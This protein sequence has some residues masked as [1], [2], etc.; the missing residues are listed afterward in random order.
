MNALT[1]I[2]SSLVGLHVT[3][4]FIMSD[5]SC[6]GRCYAH[7]DNSRG[8][9]C[10]Y[11]CHKYGDCCLD[12][13]YA[14]RHKGTSPQ[15]HTG[16]PAATTSSP[17]Q[18]TL[19]PHTPVSRNNIADVLWQVDP[20][21]FDMA[22]ITINLGNHAISGK[23]TDV[24]QD[25]LFTHVNTAPLSKPIYKALMELWD[26]YIPTRGA[27][28][29]VS[30]NDKA[31]IDNF[32]DLAMASPVMET[33]YNYLVDQHTFSGSKTVFRDKIFSLWFEPYSRSGGSSKDSS[34]FEHVF[35][36]EYKSSIVEGFHSW[37]RFYSEE[38]AGRANYLG[39]LK[40]VGP[41]MVEFS[42][43]WNGHFKKIDSFI[44]GSSPVFDMALATI[45]ILTRP[46][47][48]CSYTLNGYHFNIKQYDEA[49]TSGVQVA[50]AYT[51]F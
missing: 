46:N 20:D 28:D 22:D 17:G 45:C 13:D 44:V 18:N 42:F 51:V 39:Y 21:K 33:T 25:N 4:A 23:T 8:C 50:T 11:I 2:V 40:K 3:T 16:A 7:L 19:G 38:Q 34:G 35:V 10:N 41:Q 12:F 15:S 49:H 24:S 26:N 5:D 29:L 14:C 1:I 37:L 43:I 32:L 31:E 9:Q 47:T 36:G 48:S 6:S 30:I 27:S